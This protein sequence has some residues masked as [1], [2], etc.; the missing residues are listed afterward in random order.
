MGIA[1]HVGAVKVMKECFPDHIHVGAVAV[2][3]GLLCDPAVRGHGCAQ[4]DS[5]DG[6]GYHQLN[7]GVSAFPA[8]LKKRFHL[9]VMSL[10]I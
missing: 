1:R 10:T 3:L 5:Y 9:I 2:G 8:F 7:H 6:Q 4:Q